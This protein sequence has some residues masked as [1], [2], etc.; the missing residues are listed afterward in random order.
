[1][2]KQRWD[3]IFDRMVREGLIEATFGQR[4]EESKKGETTNVN[5]L[6]Q[7]QY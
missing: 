2:L 6:R 7:Q 5:V 3:T 4:P 1:M